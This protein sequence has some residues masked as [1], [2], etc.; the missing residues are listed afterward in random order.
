MKFELK[1]PLPECLETVSKGTPVYLVIW[2]TTPWSLPANQAVCFHPEKK[3][4]LLHS[5]GGIHH[6]YLVVASELYSSLEKLWSAHFT[7]I[8][9]FDG[10]G[11]RFLFFY[12]WLLEI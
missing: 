5:V 12:D 9:E 7:V 1:P 6:E 3:Y 11:K 8:R 2:T 10:M 4:S